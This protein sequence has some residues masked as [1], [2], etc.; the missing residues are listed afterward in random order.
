LR[1]QDVSAVLDQLALWQAEAEHPLSGRL[2]LEKVGM[3]GH[4]FGA[5]TTQA[6][7]G[8][9]MGRGKTPFLDDRIDAAVIMSPS[10]PRLGKPADAFG[11]ITMP[12]LLMTGTM[13]TAPIGNITLEDR[14]TVYPALPAGSAYELVLHR[15]EH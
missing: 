1:V 8:Q 14:F 5:M 7:T 12:W 13:D 6:V 4:S 2:D 11:A 15:A 3:S 10:A 9:A